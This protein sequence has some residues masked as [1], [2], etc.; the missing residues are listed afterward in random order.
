[1]TVEKNKDALQAWMPQ[2]TEVLLRE[3]QS[4]VPSLKEMLRELV[5]STGTDT[6]LDASIWFGVYWSDSEYSHPS[7]N[8]AATPSE[9]VD[10]DAALAVGLLLALTAYSSML[11][12]DPWAPDLEAVGVALEA[13]VRSQRA[14]NQH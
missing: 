4:H 14:S 11:A 2:Q 3:S 5:R 13:T 1:M 8:T 12:D 7:I 10:H 6:H 9:Q